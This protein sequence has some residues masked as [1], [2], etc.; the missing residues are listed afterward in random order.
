MDCETV[1]RQMTDGEIEGAIAAHLESCA[2]CRAEAALSRS[3]AAAIA[4]LPRVSVPESL[5]DS[6]MA[7]LRSL[8]PMR[9]ASPRLTRLRLGP[10]EAGWLVALCLSLLVGAWVVGG[11]AIEAGWHAVGLSLRNTSDWL[12]ARHLLPDLTLQT[13]DVR[14]AFGFIRESMAAASSVPHSW[15]F[16]LVGFGFGL[17][18]LLSRHGEIG[19]GREWKDARV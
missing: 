10:W 1:Q 9:P 6:V 8:A 19:P 15:L 7:E 11:A 3:I 5:V 14:T 4:A 13:P 2:S 16:G 18:W 17:V 12:P